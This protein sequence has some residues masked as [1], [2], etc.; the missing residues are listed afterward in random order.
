M[1]TIKYQWLPGVGRGGARNDECM[2]Q[3]IFKTVKNTTFD[4]IMVDIYQDTF[5]TTHRTY[6]KVHS[7]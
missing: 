2:E 4:S 3:R 6:P 5:V 1:D 7:H